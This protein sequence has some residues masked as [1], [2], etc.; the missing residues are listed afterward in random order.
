MIQSFKCG[1]TQALYETGKSRRF[2]NIKDVA[3][4]KLTQLAAATTL[5]FL[6]SPPGNHLEALS[7]DRVGQHS[8]RINK[9]WRVCFVWTA[10]GPADVEIVDDH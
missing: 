3:E 2:A 4:R 8:V 7:G 9:Q 1:E 6:R 5:E 10:E